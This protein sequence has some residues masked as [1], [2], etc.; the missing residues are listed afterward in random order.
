MIRGVAI[1]PGVA[2]A[3]AFRVDDALS[4][5]DPT[6][7]DAAVLSDE[8]ARFEAA[9]AAVAT[10]LDATVERV[11]TQVGESE[12]DIFRAHR[13]L[14]RDPSF[15]AKVTHLVLTDKLDARTA[16]TCAFAEYA[17]LFSKIDDEYLRD[18]LADLRDVVQR[19][20]S[21]LVSEGSVSSA[22]RTEPAVLVAYEILPSHAVMFDRMRVVGIVTESG[23]TTGHAAILARSMGIAVVSGLHG[24]MSQVHNGDLICLD[25]R[26]G[27]VVINPGPE[28]EA[29]YRK[30]QRE[31]FDLRDRLV[32][33]RDQQAVTKD[34]IKVEILANVNN[35]SDAATACRVG[36]A[37]VGL[38]R[39]EYLFLTHPSVPTEDE[40]FA[41]YKAVIEAAPNKT[42]T[43]RTLDLGGDKM[44]SYFAHG[45]E[46]NP[47]MGWR[48]IR[49]TN[50]YPD[51]F[52]TQ[53]QAILRASKFGRVQVMFPMVSTV[54]EVRHIK[55]LFRSARD[56]LTKRREAFDGEI[57]VGVMIEVPAAAVCVDDLLDESDFVSVGSNDLIQYLMAADRDNPKVAHL[58][59]PFT[60]AIYRLLQ[61]VISACTRRNVPITVCGEMAGR[62]RC[63]LPLFAMGLRSFSMTPAFVPN[64]KQIIRS[65]DKHVAR[66][67]LDLVLPMRTMLEV[68]TY[69]T[70]SVKQLCPDVALFDTFD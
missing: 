25:G 38:Y 62:P 43:I 40:Q 66:E 30:F 64:V 2:V 24:L 57:P 45:R 34:D 70:Q 37:G 39:T 14:L 19:I 11:S 3:R 21:R 69:L 7:L 16:V 36:A 4:R 63:V 59:E 33:N 48:S 58:C 1:S 61:R 55:Q 41:A 23:G 22:S 44:V 27:V 68:K 32:E 47:F 18:R 6:I 15:V 54:E 5:H 49:L 60:P 56:V 46:A 42:V 50:D 20:D 31:Y 17:E 10:D 12:A 13:Q 52:R 9:C 26:E 67:I 28:V 65:L 29:A 8:V 53:L 51:F 35:A